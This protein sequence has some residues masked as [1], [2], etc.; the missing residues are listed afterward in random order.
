MALYSPIWLEI[1]REQ[2]AALPSDMRRSFD[3]TFSTILDDPKGGGRYDKR[4]D[5]W[6]AVFAGGRGL[7]TYAVNDQYVKVIVLRIVR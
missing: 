3:A 5:Q 6:T 1:A 7:L 4:A 2:Y